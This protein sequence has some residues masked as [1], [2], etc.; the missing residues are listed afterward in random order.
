MCELESRDLVD[1]GNKNFGLAM[2]AVVGVFL[3]EDS[4][5]SS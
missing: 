1:N 4:M 3:E 5:K 2:F